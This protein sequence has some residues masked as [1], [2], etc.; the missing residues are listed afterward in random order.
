[1][2][3]RQEEEHETSSRNACSSPQKQGRAPG[4]GGGDSFWRGGRGQQETRRSLGGPQAC[5]ELCQAPGSSFTL[6]VG[7]SPVETFDLGSRSP[8]KSEH[9]HKPGSR[10]VDETQGWVGLA[11]GGFCVF[12]AHQSGFVDASSKKGPGKVRT[13]ILLLPKRP[14]PSPSLGSVPSLWEVLPL[15][16][17]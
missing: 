4:G 14:C 1:M 10:S 15:G 2:C 13:W 9:P 17:A 8:T 7:G 16:L 12:C 5:P 11:C 6:G 3:M